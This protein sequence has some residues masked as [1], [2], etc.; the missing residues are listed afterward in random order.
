MSGKFTH[1]RSIC[2]F[3]KTIFCVIILLIFI[4]FH[5][6]FDDS[7]LLDLYAIF[8]IVGF[9]SLTSFIFFKINGCFKANEK[10]VDF[11]F[12]SHKIKINY[13]D[14]E[15][16]SIDKKYNFIMF[17]NNYRIK[18]KIKAKRKNYV[19]T[20]LVKPHMMDMPDCS[21]LL[22]LRDYIENFR[23]KC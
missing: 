23:K 20:D 19:F 16:I 2:A 15:E 11:Y 14:I 3:L 17:G 22:R 6:W 18:L 9:A 13:D 7:T 12:L 1:T 8:T 10:Q 5:N 4:P 21:D